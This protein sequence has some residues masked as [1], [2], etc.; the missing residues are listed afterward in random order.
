MSCWFPRKQKTRTLCLTSIFLLVSLG[1]LLAARAAEKTIPSPRLPEAAP[2]PAGKLNVL[3]LG[4][5]LAL[6]GFGKRLDQHFREDPRVAATFTYMTCGTNPLSWLKQKP[7]TTVHTQCGYWSIE[8]IPGTAEPR[9]FQDSYGMEAHHPPR[10]HLVPK[11]EDMLAA[12][13]PDILVM[14]TGS[15]L[16]GL[17]PGMKTVQPARQAAALKKYLLPFKAMVT[18]PDSKLQKIYWVNPPISGRVSKEVQDFLLQQARAQLGPEIT[19]IDSRPMVSYPYQ[20]MEPD[21]EHFI[22]GQMDEWADK[23]F[24]IIS[25]DLNTR[26][27]APTA[28]PE[29]RHALPVEPTPTPPVLAALPVEPQGTPALTPTPTPMPTPWSKDKPLVIQGRLLF[30][31]NPIPLNELLPY[32]ESLVGYLYEVKKVLHGQYAEREILVMIPSYIALKPQRLDKFR[33]GKTY[34]LRLH[35]IE[36]SLWNTAKT[37][38]ESG[39]I[40]LLP[41][42]RVEEEARHPNH[43]R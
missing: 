35:P 4:D 10:P 14:Q 5:S 37:R 21:K 22:G 8:S 36:G 17:F 16:F 30:K 33:L 1:N 27:P 11:L 41:F 39:Q 23:V 31:S 34:K 28:T 40:N 26:A 19:V 32:Q 9:D 20:H 12:L 42:I 24:A 25:R 6:C 3:I 29:I 43:H 15:N 18:A 2:A 7:Y 13:H 38:D